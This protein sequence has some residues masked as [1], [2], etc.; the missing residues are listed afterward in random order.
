MTDS[1]F[2]GGSEF[3]PYGARAE[4]GSK[5]REH[6]RCFDTDI[7]QCSHGDPAGHGEALGQIAHGSADF[8]VGTALLP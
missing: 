3:V 8:S 2:C 6:F 1:L 5:K 7:G 4:G